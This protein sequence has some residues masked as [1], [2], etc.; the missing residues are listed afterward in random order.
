MTTKNYRN[1]CIASV[2]FVRYIAVRYAP[3]PSPLVSVAA[4]GVMHL[5]WM[6]AEQYEQSALYGMQ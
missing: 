2:S 1:Y 5:L 6:T 3:F 4:E